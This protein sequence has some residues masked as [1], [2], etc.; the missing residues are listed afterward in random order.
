[1]KPAWVQV[2]L[3]VK[4]AW[5]QVGFEPAWLQV[6]LEENKL[7]VIQYRLFGSECECP[8][9]TTTQRW[10]AAELVGQKQDIVLCVDGCTDYLNS[11]YSLIERLGAAGWLRVMPGILLVQVCCWTTCASMQTKIKQLGLPVSGVGP[12]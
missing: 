7:G 4:P 1:M 2:S 6:N 3:V 12:S 10:V 8:N 5:L 11:L 9:R